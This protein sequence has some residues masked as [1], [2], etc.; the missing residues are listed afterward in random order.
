MGRIKAIVYGVGEMGKM[1]T[2]L[3]LKG[4]RYCRGNRYWP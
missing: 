4:D 2:G 3:W 1:M